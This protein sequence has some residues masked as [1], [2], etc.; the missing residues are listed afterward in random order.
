VAGPAERGA[1]ADPDEVGED[2]G[3]EVCGEFG[4]GGVASGADADAVV[5]ESATQVRG[6]RRPAWPETGACAT[7]LMAVIGPLRPAGRSPLTGQV[8]GG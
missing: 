2:L 7:A 1:Q 6:G 5:A 4:Q 3:G 8:S